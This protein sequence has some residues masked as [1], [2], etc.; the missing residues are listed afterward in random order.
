[1]LR[2]AAEAEWKNCPGDSSV[3]RGR[4]APALSEGEKELHNTSVS[5]LPAGPGWTA[6][7]IWSISTETL[8]NM[9]M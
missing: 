2:K 7:Q 6:R 3:D 9:L 5:I 8:P 4:K 1:M